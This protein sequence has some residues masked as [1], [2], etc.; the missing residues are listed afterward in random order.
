MVVD[1]G[2]TVSVPPLKGRLYEVPF[3]PVTWIEAALLSVTV[4]VTV[5]P[6]VMLLELALIATVG[7]AAAALAVRIEIAAKGR[8]TA[9]NGPKDFMSSHRTCILPDLRSGAR[10]SREGVSAQN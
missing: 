4:R 6:E 3:D 1:V 9:R 2:A 10:C 8:R 5:C 7:T